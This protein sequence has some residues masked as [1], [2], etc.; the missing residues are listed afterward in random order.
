MMVKTIDEDYISRTRALSREVGQLRD[1]LDRVTKRKDKAV[2][3]AKIFENQASVAEKQVGS[4][5]LGC[6]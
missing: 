6:A 4:Y 5:V 2:S 1:E 3:K